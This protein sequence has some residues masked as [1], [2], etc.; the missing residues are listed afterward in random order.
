MALFWATILCAVLLLT[1]GLACAVAPI[2]S[3]R[4]ILRWMRSRSF[5]LW[6]LTLATLWFIWHLA[7]L[8]EA[9]LGNYKV[10][11]IVAF[12]GAAIICYKYLAD[13]L[14]VRAVCAL[15][16]MTANVLLDAAY[17]EVPTSRLYMVSVVYIGIVLAIYFA[18]VPFK[19]RDLME[20][21]LRK[22]WFAQILGTI[23]CLCGIGLLVVAFLYPNM[24][25]ILLVVSGPSGCGKTTV[26]QRLVKTYTPNL[27]RVVTTTTR[28]PRPGEVNGVDYHFF[29]PE[30]FETKVQEGAFLEHAL[31]YKNRYGTL[32]ESVYGPLKAGKDL[33]INVDVQ[34]V[35][36]FI[37]A[38]KK[39]PFLAHQMVTIFI[40][41]PKEELERRLRSRGSDSEET[42]QRRLQASDDENKYASQ[43]YLQIDSHDMDSDFEEMRNKY[44]REKALRSH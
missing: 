28:A 21:F 34:G 4:H 38:A 13:F 37:E 26:C 11:L 23:A 40:R 39:D 18:A 44:L 24:N 10:L 31:V 8:G 33:V 35:M 22:P 20:F 16:L 17:Q 12:G 32:K 6:A 25:G 1:P 30:M 9:D 2:G 19:L 7:H 41:C 29:T 43:F 14:S 42:I 36:S 5:T 15:Y 3:S 27:Q